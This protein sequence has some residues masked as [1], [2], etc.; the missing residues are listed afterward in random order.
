MAGMVPF[1]KK[2]PDLSNFDM[3]DLYGALNDY[4]TDS[5]PFRRGF[6]L[7]SFKV[8]IQEEGN[9]YIVTAELPGIQKEEIGI[10][11]EDGRI[12]ISVTRDENKV[13]EGKNY[14]HKESRHSSMSRSI[15]LP[16]AQGEDMKAKLSDGVLSITIP[17]KEK[18]DKSVK[19]E[20]D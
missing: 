11:M 7:N 12:H 3:N 8:D 1:S 17:K 10:S 6:A 4:F 18:V 5:W 9:Q 13:D 19:I 16:D 14:I 15:Y 2:K 20:I